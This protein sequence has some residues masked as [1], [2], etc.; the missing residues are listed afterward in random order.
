MH[1]KVKSIVIIGSGLGGL[2]CGYIL[3]KHGLKVMILE[4]SNRIGG[5]LQTFRYHNN[6]FDTGFHYVGGL[7]EGES[8]Y[9]LFNYFN[10]LDLPW[11]PLDEECFDEV[12]IGNQSFAFA[13]G[14]ERFVEELSKSF[15]HQHHNLKKYADFL[16]HV[17]THIYDSFQPKQ[18]ESFYGS[19]LFTRS[20]YEFLNETISDPLLRKVLSGTS[21]KMELDA[22]T[23]PLYIF[24]QINN[25]YLQS[26]WRLKGGGSQISNHL[27][28]SIKAMGGEIRT[29]SE[30]TKLIEHDGCITR[31]EI[32]GKE[33]IE[34]QSVISNI[35]PAQTLSL[36]KESKVLRNIYRK[37]ITNIKNTFGMFTVNI[38]LKSDTLPYQ[39][40]NI[41]FHTNNA[42]LWRPKNQPTESVLLSYYIPQD[43]SRYSSAIDLLTPMRWEEVGKWA[44]KPLQKRG[45]EYELFKAK[46]RDECLKLVEKHL[47]ELRNSIEHIHTSTPLSYQHYLKMHEGSAYGIRK[48][49][50]NTMGTILTPRTPIP[51]LLLT[52]QN[53]NLHGI[54]GVSMTSIFTCAEII[55]METIVNELE[56]I[57][58]K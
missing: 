17:G 50:A 43:E 30:V 1:K 16:Q 14:H 44:D 55:G 35:H 18:A 32:N 37:R 33:E 25:S 12:I 39:N 52:G 54:L 24:A 29:C 28:Q 47:P 7:R 22:N 15:P 2:E 10:L 26:T 46:K 21:L 58:T 19:S 41:Y 9:P 53:L 34:C 23:L 38:H 36:V 4:Q 49:Y 42:D 5:C 20:A 45:E 40:K 6:L 13:N 8:L 3:A 11:H 51:N 31:V 57:P 27:A 56:I 48:D